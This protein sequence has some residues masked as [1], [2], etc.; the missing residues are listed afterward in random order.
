MRFNTSTR[1]KARM[2]GE[3]EAMEMART[4]MDGFSKGDVTVILKNMD[5]K[6]AHEKWT[7]VFGPSDPRAKMSS[8]EFEKD[9]KREI[10]R[11][12]AKPWNATWSIDKI[13]M[14]GDEAVV[15]VNVEGSKSIFLPMILLKKGRN[16]RLI[17]IPAW[18]Y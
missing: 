7:D 3:S 9:Y 18:S 16:W 14:E 8:K 4:I 6:A 11:T 5:F 10:Q 17:Q 1:R 15:E 2:T 12:Y 13:T